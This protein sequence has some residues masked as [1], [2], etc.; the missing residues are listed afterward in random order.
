MSAITAA[1]PRATSPITSP[2]TSPVTATSETAADRDASPNRILAAALFGFFLVGLD[3]LV[4]TVALPAISHSLSGG[5]A[6]LQW[7]VDGYTLA[8][9]ALM[10]SSGALSDRVGADR[11]YKIGLIGFTAASVACGVAPNLGLLIAARL[12]QGTAASVM[13]PASL[14]LVRQAFPEVGARAKAI[15][16]W[17]AAGSSAAAAGPVAGGAITS[18]LSWRAIF[19]LNVPAGILALYLLAKAPRSPRQATHF[20][21]AGLVTS[22]LTLAG[23]TY[24]VIEGG[25]KGFDSTPVLASLGVA[26][27]TADARAGAVPRPD[28]E[29]GRAHV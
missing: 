16:I 17:T 24:A 10:L 1:A 19:F 13:L 25:A 20:D 11:A 3:A 4:V 29:I 15:A 9:A 26:A 27:G 21:L 28:R 18:A 7:V 6:G 14:A 2:V 5:M 23:L 22:V 12:V 8:F